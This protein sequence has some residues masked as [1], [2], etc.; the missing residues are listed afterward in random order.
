[1]VGIPAELFKGI[2]PMAYDMTGCR[3]SEII[4]VSDFKN[5]G[6]N[7]DFGNYIT[8]IR[9]MIMIMIIVQLLMIMIL[10]IVIVIMIKKIIHR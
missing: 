6:S 8:R 9:M 7:A 2:G 1:M 3:N 4:R 10:I 5:R